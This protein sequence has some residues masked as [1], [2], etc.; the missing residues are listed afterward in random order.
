M[1]LDSKISYLS[2]TYSTNRPIETHLHSAECHERT[3]GAYK[4]LN[5]R[6]LKSME[7]TN[8]LATNSLLSYL[9][10]DFWR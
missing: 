9:L 10:F 4:S 1:R 7:N 8:F 3:R 5:A 2:A 6:Q